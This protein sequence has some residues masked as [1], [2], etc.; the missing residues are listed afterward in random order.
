MTDIEK[1]IVNLKGHSVALCKGE[2]VVVSDGKGISP[3]LGLIDSGK[4]FSGYS[5]ADYVV[6]KAAAMLFAKMNVA[7]VHGRIM[8]SLA[9]DFLKRRGVAYSFDETA[10]RIRNN[11]GT[12]M[13]PMEETV[14][15]IDDPDAA[16]DALRCRLAELKATSGR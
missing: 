8:S 6:G 9:A 3:L 14:L 4:D 15:G 5:C 13:C 12:G 2:E 1:A 11:A 7:C 10:E 16:L